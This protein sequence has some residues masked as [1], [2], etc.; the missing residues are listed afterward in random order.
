[1]PRWLESATIRRADLL[2]QMRE[3]DRL[4]Y[5][6]DSYA[7][8]VVDARRVLR[9]AQE[10]APTNTSERGRVPVCARTLSARS[11]KAWSEA[12]CA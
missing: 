6:A 9:K 12:S 4:G 7:L 3:V 2:P 10:N 11:C 5:Y 1:L 8:R